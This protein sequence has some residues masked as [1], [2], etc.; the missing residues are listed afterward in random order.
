MFTTRTPWPSVCILAAGFLLSLAARAVQPEGIVYESEAIAAPESAWTRDERAPGRWML[1]TKEEEIDKKRSGGAVLASPAVA[2]DRGAPEEG[3][4]PLHC[5]VDDLEPGTYLVYISDPGKRPLAYSPDGIDWTKYEGGELSLGACALP[6]GRFEFWIDDRFAHPA[7]NPGPG[8]FD[9]VRFVPVPASALNFTRFEY[10]RDITTQVLQDGNGF[11]T[12]IDA[13]TDLQGFEVSGAE[14]RGGEQAGQSFGCALDRDG[15]YYLALHMN[16]DE[17]GIERLL[18]ALNGQETGCIVGAGP[19]GQFVASS[20]Q[21][22]ALHKGDKLTFTAAAPVGYYRVYGLYFSEQPIQP[23][24][25]RFEHLEAWSPARG[26]ADLCWT[27]TTIV[28]TGV[29]EYGEGNFAAVTEP[30]EYAGRNHRAPLEGL[31]PAKEYQARVR[32][33]Y[34]GKPLFSDVVRF[35]PA[36]PPDT[37]TANLTVPLR[38]AEPADKARTNWPVTMGLP[39]PRG[40]VADPAHLR[41]FAPDGRAVALQADEFSRWPD[42]SLKWALLSFPGATQTGPEPAEYRL[43]ARA[44][45]DTPAPTIAPATLT[46]TDDAW[47]LGNGMVE[48]EVR[49]TSPASSCAYAIDLDGDGAISASERD[50]ARGSALRLQVALPDGSQLLCGPPDREGPVA[51]ILGPVRALLQWTGPLVTGAGADS[52]WRYLMQARIASQNRELGL[53]VGVYNASPNPAFRELASVQLVATLP[54]GAITQAAFDGAPLAPLTDSGISVRQLEDRAFTVSGGAGETAGEHPRGFASAITNAAAVDVFVPHFWQTYPKAISIEPGAVRAHLLPQ[55]P[56]DAYA[57]AEYDPV[58]YK[59]FAWFKNGN[60]EFRGGQMMR[61]DVSLR[62]GGTGSADADAETRLAWAE[63]P[64]LVTPPPEY[65]CGSGIFGRPLFPLTP[66]VWDEYEAVFDQSF[67]ASLADRE[68]ERTYGWMHF[69]DWY[70]ERYCN[71]GNS[72]YDT[73]WALGLQWARTGRRD[74]Y[75]RGL[76]MALHYGTVDTRHGPFTASERCVVWEHSFKH[77]GTSIP[78]EELRV[79]AND[80]GM[81]QYM[82]SFKGMFP[83][84]RDAQGHVYDQGAWLYAALTGDPFH[85]YVAEHIADTQARTLTPSFDFT[86]ERSGG[87][88]IINAVTS[89]NFSGNPYYLNAARIMVERCFEREDPVKGGWPHY[90][91]ANETGGEKVLGGKAFAVGILSHGLLRYLEQ[92]TGDCQDVRDMLIRAADWLMNESWVPGKGFRYITN[93]PNYRDTGSRGISSAL[94][95]EIIAFAYE[96]T[97]DLKYRE[98]WK[99][100]MQGVLET[101]KHGMGKAFTQITRQ[102]IYGLDRACKAGIAGMPE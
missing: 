10:W 42:G 34:L 70:G 21:P 45:W 40:T 12:E 33:E 8:Y 63:Q 50:A 37:P 100:M 46:E 48:L 36:P 68:T 62:F 88:P 69:G 28:K 86:I 29:V 98:F 24:P 44:S 73:A 84:A 35:R 15:T 1:W 77:V 11:V 26:K 92:E 75:E 67:E 3:A 102:T 81:Q 57:G 41:L 2:Q 20:N 13:F 76:E 90:P 101:E 64:L 74:I 58:Y 78:V 6:E 23:P 5:V 83:G 87:W 56:P 30:T 43:E 32:S 52:G 17:D 9:Y 59:L 39:F 93:A 95:A 99:D 19:D 54:G 89:Y 47:H 14:L 51:Q 38:L 72:E 71:Y 25:P 94:N 49:K 96:E 61:H 66:G 4:P 85:R 97:G 82:S 79:P 55:L 22:I 80:E 53:S 16:D 31:D 91:P 65:L 7:S 27:T 18:L 60:Y